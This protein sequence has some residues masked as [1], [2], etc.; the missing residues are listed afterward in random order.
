MLR[1][2]TMRRS[3]KFAAEPGGRAGRQMLETVLA[4]R[5]GHYRSYQILATI[6]AT[7]DGVDPFRA[8]R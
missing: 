8:P 1:F 4:P 2:R 6:G 3:T 5:S 7:T